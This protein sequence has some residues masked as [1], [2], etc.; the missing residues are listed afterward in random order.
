MSEIICIGAMYNCKNTEES[1]GEICVKC[2]KCG[3]FNPLSARDYEN[4]AGYWQKVKQE[5]ISE[6]GCGEAIEMCDLAITALTE[7]A[8]REQNGGWISV[9]DRLPEYNKIHH[10]DYY[11]VV[12]KFKRH[13]EARHHDYWH[14]SVWTT[15]SGKLIDFITHWKPLPQ[16]PKE[17]RG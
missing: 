7:K 3:R 17:A 6:E 12:D 4:A 11:L 5:L 15:A 2:N 14:S 1:F 8:E 9:A 16:P 10:T 13:Y